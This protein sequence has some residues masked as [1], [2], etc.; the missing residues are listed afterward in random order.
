MQVA[1][2]AFSPS[3]RRHLGQNILQPILHVFVD[4]LSLICSSEVQ[5][6][7]NITV[8][9]HYNDVFF[10]VI[11]DVST[12]FQHETAIAYLSA[13]EDADTATFAIEPSQELV[14][15]S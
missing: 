7:A 11:H 5:Y 13:S 9:K 1:H 14:H 2:V 15:H 4:L 12:S 10:T 8:L 3:G 6:C